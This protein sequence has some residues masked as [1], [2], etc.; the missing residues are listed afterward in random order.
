M[1]NCFYPCLLIVMFNILSYHMS[2]R[3]EYHIVMTVPLR[4]PH[5]TI[6]VWYLYPVACN[7]ADVLFTL[8]LFVSV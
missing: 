3:S 4:F 7:M 1:Y 8:F 2:L 5:K 6:F